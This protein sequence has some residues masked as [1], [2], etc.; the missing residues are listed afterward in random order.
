MSMSRFETVMSTDRQEKPMVLSIN[1]NS[2][3]GSS[4]RGQGHPAISDRESVGEE[5]GAPYKVG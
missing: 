4:T 2:G 5:E 3:A 1:V